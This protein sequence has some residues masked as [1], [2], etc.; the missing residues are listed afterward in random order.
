[1]RRTHFSFKY[2]QCC[3]YICAK[4][5]LF[6]NLQYKMVC[7]EHTATSFCYYKD[8]KIIFLSSSK[9]YIASNTTVKKQHGPK[10]IRNLQ[11]RHWGIDENYKICIGVEYCKSFEAKGAGLC[12]IYGTS[13]C[14]TLLLLAFVSPCHLTHKTNSRCW[15]HKVKPSEGWQPQGKRD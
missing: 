5:Y 14:V 15:E 6:R 7:W 4:A 13:K 3:P 12:L 11:K 9:E 1:M 8:L 2:I 10:M